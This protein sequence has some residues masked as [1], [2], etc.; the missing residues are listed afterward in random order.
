[1]GD[2]EQANSKRVLHLTNGG[3]TSVRRLPTPAK[4]QVIYWEMKWPASA[5]ASATFFSTLR[6]KRRTRT[7]YWLPDGS[8]VRQPK[9][10]D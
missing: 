10:L 3:D 8:K 4:G 5:C 1:M 2:S 6:R 7:D 9:V